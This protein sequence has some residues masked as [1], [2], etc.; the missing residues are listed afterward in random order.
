M[1]SKSSSCQ[2]VRH[3]VKKYVLASKNMSLRQRYVMKSKRLSHQIVR[4]DVKQFV[5]MAKN[6]SWLQKV[7][8]DVKKIVI[9][10][11]CYRTNVMLLAVMPHNLNTIIS[12]ALQGSTNKRHR[13]SSGMYFVNHAGFDLSLLKCICVWS[14][15]AF[16]LTLYDLLDN[17]SHELASIVTRYDFMGDLGM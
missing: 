3:D 2:K 8:H 9:T 7:C 1:T 6:A 12:Q 16:Q 14:Q 10:Q 11:K 13:A 4:H 5:M 17:C 15:L